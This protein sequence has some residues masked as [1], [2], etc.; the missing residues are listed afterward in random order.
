M[1]RTRELAFRTANAALIGAISWLH[2]RFDVATTY[3]LGP[4]GPAAQFE[5]CWFSY[6]PR[7]F[8]CTGN[9]DWAADAENATRSFLFERMKDR[10]VFYDIGAHGGVYTITALKRF[11]DLQVHSFEPQPEDLI[12]NLA[13]N[14]LSTDNVHGVALGAVSG[15]VRMTTGKRSSN[16]VSAN[17]DRS[18]P[19]VRLDDY[20]RGLPAPDWIKIDIEGL[21]LPALK[22]A[23]QT[24]RSS[25]P[26][27]ICE[28]NRISGRYGTTPDELIGYL[29]SLGYSV[30][31]LVDGELQPVS[32]PLPYSADWNYWFIP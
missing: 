26:T 14:H 5:G 30:H 29:A 28:I 2:R 17:G 13:L 23:E 1:A 3:R 7:E 31:A 8:G 32:V 19:M 11:P 18:V 25:R 9:I 10:Q 21:E 22:G 12:R 6:H 4:D 15:T 24:L 20:A 16:H 27:I